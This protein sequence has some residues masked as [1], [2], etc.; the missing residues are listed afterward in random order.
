L[1]TSNRVSVALMGLLAVALAALPVAGWLWPS[2]PLLA[3]ALLALNGRLYAFW[4]RRRGWAFTLAALPWHWL[5]YLY[6]SLSFSLGTASYWMRGT[7]PLH[8]DGALP[9]DEDGEQPVP[10]HEA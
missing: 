4:V 8:A 10:Q 1:Q 5:Y 2:V 9:A 6:N 3:A 7:R